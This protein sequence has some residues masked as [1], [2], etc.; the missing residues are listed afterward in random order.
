MAQTWPASRSCMFAKSGNGTVEKLG[1]TDH[2]RYPLAHSCA[3]YDRD[4]VSRS[5]PTSISCTR[6]LHHGM[7]VLSPILAWGALLHPLRPDIW[8]V[9]PHGP[10]GRSSASIPAAPSTETQRVSDSGEAMTRDCDGQRRQQT[11]LTRQSWAGASCR[12]R[13]MRAAADQGPC[14][15]GVGRVP[16]HAGPEHR[17]GGCLRIGSHLGNGTK[18]CHLRQRSPAERD[19][20]DRLREALRR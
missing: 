7:R 18:F 20:V 12:K 14:L 4:A 16:V 15:S 2:L 6:V 8:P 11:C 3:N 17:G 9:Y 13:G 5:R 10:Q 1:S 19:G